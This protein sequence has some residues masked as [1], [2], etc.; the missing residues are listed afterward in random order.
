MAMRQGESRGGRQQVPTRPD[1]T[2]GSADIPALDLREVVVRTPNTSEH[3]MPLKNYGSGSGRLPQMLPP[4]PHPTPHPTPR[5]CPWRL[6][7]GFFF[8]ASSFRVVVAFPAYPVW[9]LRP[10]G[11]GW[12]GGGGGGGGAKALRRQHLGAPGCLAQ[13]RPCP[14]TWGARAFFCCCMMRFLQGQG[15]FVCRGVP[16]FHFVGCCAAQLLGRQLGAHRL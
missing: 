15:H 16:P 10:R 12:D 7:C 3:T 4:L 11:M 5:C 6:A 13:T 9:L 2:R 8:C 1:P 14:A